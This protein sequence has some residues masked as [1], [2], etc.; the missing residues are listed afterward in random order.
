MDRTYKTVNLEAALKKR[1]K[2][3]E[4]DDF[5]IDAI[6]PKRDIWRE[7]SHIYFYDEID[8]QT[9]LLFLRYYE[10]AI[11]YIYAKS[12]EY[13]VKHDGQPCEVV[14]I[15]VN[16]PGGDVFCSLALYDYLKQ[17]EIPAIGIV[18]GQAAS[19]ASILM[20]GCTEKLMTQHSMMLIHELSSGTWGKLHQMKQDFENWE[21][22]MDLIKDVYRKETKI[23]EAE[24]EK[25]LEPDYYWKSKKCKEYGLVN[26]IIGEREEPDVEELEELEESLKSLEQ[27]VENQKKAI[28]E[29]KGEKE[30]K[31]PKAKKKAAAKKEEPKEEVTSSNDDHKSDKS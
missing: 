11:D 18:E 2:I 27:L 5:P 20:Q 30:P 31:A 28:A 12:G 9:Q 8:P 3:E 7:G 25:I 21:S 22:M 23:P 24:L 6:T 16:S 13:A 14:T 1:W 15:H 26:H 19:G 4:E 17:A 29:L 10:Q